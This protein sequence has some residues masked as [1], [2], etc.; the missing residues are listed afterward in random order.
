VGTATELAKLKDA[1]KTKEEKRVPFDY[2]RG[3]MSGIEKTHKETED[4][5]KRA[6]WL[7]NVGKQTDA[8]KEYYKAYNDVKD[9]LTLL[10][11]RAKVTCD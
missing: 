4:P 6:R 1:L 8:N 7:K 5:K 11:E 10:E 3:K 9:L 2:Y